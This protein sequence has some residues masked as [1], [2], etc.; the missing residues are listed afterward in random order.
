MSIAI[1]NRAIKA[2][3]EQAFGRGKVR[4]RGSRGTAWGWVTV[5][6]DWT[7]RDQDQRRT[8]TTEVYRLLDAAG[9]LKQIGTYGYD[10]P[11]SDYGYGNKMHLNFN[12]CRYYR[13]MRASDGTLLAMDDW[14]GGQWRAVEG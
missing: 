5:D 10:D 14:D 12:T 4:V 11:G 7:P 6:I 8:M 1:R 2:T 13:T 9:L 3:L